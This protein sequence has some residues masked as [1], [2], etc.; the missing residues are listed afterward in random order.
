MRLFLAQ[1]DLGNGIFVKQML[2]KFPLKKTEFCNFLT[3]LDGM[4][5]KNI[6]NLFDYE[7]GKV[8]FEVLPFEHFLESKTE[9]VITLQKYPKMKN[10]PS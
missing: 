7:D 5:S 1:I 2:S 9:N 10:I 3:Y 6:P 8:N 4:F